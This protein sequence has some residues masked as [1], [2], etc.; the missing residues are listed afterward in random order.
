[1]TDT[2]TVELTM[3]EVIE[4]RILQAGYLRRL[5]GGVNPRDLFG[6]QWDFNTGHRPVT[7][8]MAELHAEGVILYDKLGRAQFGE[9]YP[10]KA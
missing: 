3:H 5:G 2:V 1:M 8:A 10:Q 6:T 9:E 4:L 7:P